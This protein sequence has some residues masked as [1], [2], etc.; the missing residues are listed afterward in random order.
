MFA[1][2]LTS[3]ITQEDVQSAKESYRLLQPSES[4]SASQRDSTTATSQTDDLPSTDA[5]EEEE[6]MQMEP[7]QA[8]LQMMMSMDMLLDVEVPEQDPI[9]GGKQKTD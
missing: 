7:S 4:L 6:V 2:S 9:V 5:H 3:P 1:A 8:D